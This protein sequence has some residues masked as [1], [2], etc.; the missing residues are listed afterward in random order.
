M[1][2]NNT[3]L[4]AIKEEAEQLQKNLAALFDEASSYKDATKT[5]LG[6]SGGLAEATNR[7]VTLSEQIAAVIDALEKLDYQTLSEIKTHTELIMEESSK[8]TSILLDIKT[9]LDGISINI[10][11]LKKELSLFKE[12]VC[13][14][15][16]ASKRE[17]STIEIKSR[18]FIIG[19]VGVAF[20]IL[21]IVT[22]LK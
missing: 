9:K 5:M 19:A 15:I 1:E 11:D 21:L 17:L 20:I 16:E 6:V 8:V 13:E 2:S 3:N 7:L 4:M 14:K 18:Y 10:Q 12:M 22:L